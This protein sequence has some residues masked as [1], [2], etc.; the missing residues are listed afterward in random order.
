MSNFVDCD[1]DQAFLLPPDLRDWIPS[2][3]LAHF[4]IEAV[5]RV[6]L[7]AFKVNHR[8][9]GSAQYHPRMMLAL[10]I[11]CYAN[12]IFS[13]RRIERA[14]HRDIGVRFVAANLHPDHD[15]IARF[16]RENLD[17]VSESF[18]QVLLLARELKLLRVGLVSVDGSKFKANASKHRSVTYERAGGLIGQLEGEIAALLRRAE[19]ADVA[20]EEDPQALPKEI[21]RRAALRDKLDAIPPH[22]VKHDAD[23][24]GQG[25]GCALLAPLC[26]QA[27]RPGLQPVRPR[28]VQHHR[29]G[30]IE[31]TAQTCIA[32]LGDP[33]DKIPFAGLV[34]ARGQ[35]HPRA[36]ILRSPEPL[37]IVDRGREGQG[38]DVADARHGHQEAAHPV[39]P[40]Q[41][42][43]QLLKAGE[44]AAQTRP[45]AQDR[46]GRG[47]QHRVA[48]D[49]FPDT[50]LVAALRDL[51]HLQAEVAQDTA[52][53]E[54][55][56]GERVQH[57][58][59][60]GQKRPHLLRRHRFAV[61]RTEPAHLQQPRNTFRIPAVRLDRHRLQRGLHLPGLHQHGL[62]A[63]VGQ[64]LVQPVGQGTGFEADRGDP[65]RQLAHE[66]NQRFRCAGDP[67]LRHD[68]ALLAENADCRA[69]QRYI[70]PDKNIHVDALSCKGV[71]AR[72]SARPREHAARVRATTPESP[73][74]LQ[75]EMSPVGAEPH[76]GISVRL[77]LP[78]FQSPLTEPGVPISGTG[79]SSGIM[80]LAHGPPGQR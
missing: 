32:G 54:L 37:G 41:I 20:G 80:R 43:D 6:G 58:S 16:R 53:R 51:A 2:D 1:R 12:G 48:C 25:N 35:S 33:A 15:T 23:T 14:T 34:P 13:S 24:P 4:V 59:A 17:A 19:A 75:A 71:G 28:V 50:G 69:C 29:G 49:Q 77:P 73:P 46:I 74:S 76:Y 78:R 27:L 7:G 67:R 10:L 21:A 62:E 18:L 22:P 40:G 79:L 5:E 56:I 63:G 47:F 66:R 9:T 70:Q 44:L 68:L 52:Q 60:R 39:L 31:R 26:C 72:L 45:R 8:G 64:P 38:Y 57:G 61:H 30:L 11:Y 3:D 55:Q 42:A 36:E 65:V